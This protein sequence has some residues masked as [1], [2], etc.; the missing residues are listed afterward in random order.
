MHHAETELQMT[1]SQIHRPVV[2]NGPLMGV[3]EDNLA[4][5]YIVW[6]R[7]LDLAQVA[8]PEGRIDSKRRDNRLK[9]SELLSN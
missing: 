2:G 5:Q 9:Q 1:S 6:L 4:V 7:L 8:S 3:T